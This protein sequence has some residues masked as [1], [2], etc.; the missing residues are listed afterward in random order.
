MF[1]KI[2][3]QFPRELQLLIYS[4]TD[5]FARRYA[6]HLGFKRFGNSLNII[7]TDNYYKTLGCLD[8]FSADKLWKLEYKLYKILREKQEFFIHN[9]RPCLQHSYN[10]SSD[11]KENVY[12]EFHENNTNIWALD[13]YKTLISYALKISLNGYYTILFIKKHHLIEFRTKFTKRVVDHHM[14]KHIKEYIIYYTQSLKKFD[15]NLRKST[16]PI[17]I[18]IPYDINKIENI[19][20]YME[21]LCNNNIKSYI[22]S[23]ESSNIQ[24]NKLIQSYEIYSNG[25]G[26]YSLN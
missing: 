4:Y 3:E 11:F 24:I 14:R 17:I 5:E 19:K 23:P 21:L 2:L 6:K 26:K 7:F 9:K 16:K 20:V 1:K 18:C 12:P 13:N 10:S 15:N 25:S 22:L 8:N